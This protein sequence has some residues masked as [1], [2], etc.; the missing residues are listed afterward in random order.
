MKNY[1]HLMMEY[2]QK[3]WVLMN[4]PLYQ[5]L[6]NLTGR[7]NC[8]VDLSCD[9]A[10]E[11]RDKLG[12]EDRAGEESEWSYKMQLAVYCEDLPLATKLADKLMKIPPGSSR[13]FAYYHTRVF[14]FAL[15]SLWNCKKRKAKNRWEYKWAFKKYF[16]MVNEWVMKKRAINLVHKLMILKAERLSMRRRKIDPRDL[17]D[18]Y[19]KAISSSMR[20]GFLQDA[21]LAAHLASRCRKLEVYDRK[22]YHERALELYSSWGAHGI[23]DYLHTNIGSKSWSSYDSITFTTL[24]ESTERTISGGSCHGSPSSPG[25]GGYRARERFDKTVVDEHKK[26]LLASTLLYR[27]E[28]V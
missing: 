22:A 5:C 15:I 28:I 2:N 25:G 17:S 9:K 24:A 8:M 20:S 3:F 23:V 18:A 1:I 27:K 11:F 14:F 10:K 16:N 7:S 21:A 13:S 6:L 19:D 26:N 12:W 4:V